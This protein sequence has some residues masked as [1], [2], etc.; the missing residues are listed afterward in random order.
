MVWQFGFGRTRISEFMRL[1]VLLRVREVNLI[2]CCA[3]SNVDYY[4][5][6]EVTSVWCYGPVFQAEVGIG[7]V[8]G[9]GVQ[10]CFSSRRR[11]TRCSRDWSS[12]VCSSD[13]N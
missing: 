1:L 10:L 13:L 3:S 4:M 11:H 8:A 7:D 9:T 2:S 5:T 12:D 6:D